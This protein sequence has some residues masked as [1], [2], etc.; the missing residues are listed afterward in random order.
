MKI[1]IVAI[2]ESELE[3][4]RQKVVLN[5]LDVRKAKE[6]INKFE[7]GQKVILKDFYFFIGKRVV[8]EVRG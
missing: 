2:K 6:V 7:N 4:L 5:E 8:L 3:K 1:L